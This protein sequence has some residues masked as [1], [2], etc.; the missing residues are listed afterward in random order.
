MG[1]YTKPQWGLASPTISPRPIQGA[2]P[3]CMVVSG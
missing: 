2:N 1:V 3:M